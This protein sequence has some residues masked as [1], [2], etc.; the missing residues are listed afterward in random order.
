MTDPSY[1]GQILVF[2]IPRVGNYG[3]TPKKFWESPKIQVAGVVVQ[4]CSKAFEE[5]C[6][7][8]QV[9]LLMNIDTRALIKTLRGRVLSGCFI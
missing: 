4:E 1:Q 2:S 7:K 6:Q 8:F 5:W 9:P 3:I